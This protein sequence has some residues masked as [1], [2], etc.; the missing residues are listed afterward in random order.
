[1]KRI[2][3][4]CLIVLFLITQHTYASCLLEECSMAVENSQNQEL[5]QEETEELFLDVV[6]S[7][8]WEKLGQIQQNP[9][10]CRFLSALVY[11][12]LF[13]YPLSPSDATFNYMV[14]TYMLYLLLCG[15]RHS[16][17][18]QFGAINPFYGEQESTLIVEIACINTTFQD[19]G[20]SE[21]LFSPNDGLT[22]SNITV[23]SNTEIEF[24]L[25]IAA[26]APVGI[27]TVT[28]IWDD[29]NQFVTG[30]NVFE[31]TTPIND[32][33]FT[34][35]DELDPGES[36]ID[37]IVLPIA[38]YPDDIYDDPIEPPDYTLP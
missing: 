1:M 32:I 19:D 28:V 16:I 24:E 38:D 31:V 34:P 2:A 36:P 12:S 10:F 29:G 33:E 30:V 23:F 8:D 22:V 6:Q 5:I 13:A 3:V 17:P 9:G 18:P 35:P 20:V 7:A 14:N 37:V 4:I 15:S 21:I 26:D 25:E 11:L 27:K